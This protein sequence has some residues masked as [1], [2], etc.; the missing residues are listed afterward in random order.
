MVDIEAMVDLCIGLRGQAPRQGEE[1][2]CRGH[3]RR[4]V[5][6]R[7]GVFGYLRADQEPLW[8]RFQGELEGRAEELL[9]LAEPTLVDIPGQEADLHGP[10][11]FSKTPYSYG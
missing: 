9:V 7:P 3:E 1:P 2:R 10:F 5:C 4:M 8:V 6:Q 11:A